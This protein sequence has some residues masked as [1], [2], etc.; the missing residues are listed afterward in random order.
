MKKMDKSPSF[1][2]LFLI[3][4]LNIA[5]E[6]VGYCQNI[7]SNIYIESIAIC[8][9]NFNSISDSLEKILFDDLI[10][11]FK[12]KTNRTI[13][14]TS[15]MIKNITNRNF[16]LSAAFISDTEITKITKEYGVSHVLT[17]VAVGVND[18]IIVQVK[19]LDCENRFAKYASAN[20][21]NPSKRRLMKCNGQLIEQLNIKFSDKKMIPEFEKK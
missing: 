1:I 7:K 19:L 12:Q 6:N 13:V 17:G 4:I 9:F 16:D 2:L 14:L 10:N 21:Y 20:C 11:K 15:T 5:A 18:A 3:I 8:E